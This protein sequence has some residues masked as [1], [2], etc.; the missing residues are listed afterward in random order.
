MRKILFIFLLSTITCVKL[1]AQCNAPVINSFSPNTGFIGSTVTITG[2]NFDPIPAN[3]QVFFGATQAT[4]Q[5]A[6]FGVLT[7]TVPVGATT[8]PVA[9]KNACNLIAYSNVSFNGIFCP[10]PINSTTYNNVAF[11]LGGVYGAYNMLA[12]DMDNDGKPD[13]VSAY[14]GL[15]VA[16]NNSTPGN[17]NFT[18]YNFGTA[19]NYNSSVSTA[20]FD[21]DGRRDIFTT[22]NIYRN[23]STGPGNINFQIYGAPAN[24]Y[25]GYQ[26]N[27]GDFNNDGKI[28]IVWENASGTMYF[29]MNTSTGP[30][31]I[32]FTYST[33]LYVQYRCTGIQCVDVDGDGKTDVL[34]T[35]GDGNRMIALRNTTTTGSG[36]FTFAG[37]QAFN[38]GGAYPYRCQIADFDKD[39]RIDLATVN[40]NSGANTVNTAVFRNTS[41][42][43]N[44]SFATPNTYAG[45]QNNYRIG[46]G[47]V[48]GDGYPDIVTKSLA[49]QAFAVYPNTSTGSG[50]ISFAN[51]FDYS[52]AATAEVSGIVIGDLDGD[53]VPDIAT[54]GVNS[55][56]IR[57]HRNT[58]SQ[59]DNT[60][61][62]AACKNIIAAL[63][64]TGSVTVTAAMI[65]NGSSDACGIGSLQ[66]N[67][68]ASVT[69]TCANIGANTVTL[70]VTDRAGNVSTCTS[71]VTVAPAAIIVAGQTTVCQGQTVTLTANQGDSYQWLKDGVIIPG[72]NSQSYVATVTGNYSV[73]VTNAGGCSGTSAETPVTVNLNPTVNVTPSGNAS[74]CPPSGKVVLSASTSSIYQWK[75]NGSN[76]S[77]ATQ[78]SY[79]ATA[80]G[81]YSVQVI[82]LFGCSATSS[83][84]SVSA[85]D[86]IAPTAR[87]KNVTVALNAAKTASVTVS[88]INNGSSDNCGIASVTISGQTTYGCTDVGNSIPVT[89]TVTDNSG[90]ISTCTA[91]VTVTDPNSYCNKIPVAVCK[92]LTLSANANCNADATAADFDGGSTDGD[93]DP[94]T[95]SVA[96]AGP[97][98]KGVTNVVLT[99]DDGRG[100]VSS[101][102][103]TVT[104]VDDQKPVITTDGNK[105]VNAIPGQCSADVTVSARA[106]DNCTVGAPSGTRSDNLPLNA[107][108]PV[109]TT[110]ITWTVV[111]A[112][113]NAAD[114]V[115]QTVTV[116]DIQAPTFL[117]NGSSNVNFPAG[118]GTPVSS[119]S[120]MVKTFSDPL[121]SGAVIT[122]ASLTYTAV[123]QGWGNTGGSA[124]IDI[125][126]TRIGSNVL[127]HYSTTQT[128]SYT[129]PLPNYVYGGTNTLKMYFLG[130][131]GWQSYW[132]GG[133]LTLYY[134]YQGCTASI[135]V[136]NDANK[137]GATVNIRIPAAVD[138]CGTATV[139]GTRS[140]GFPVTADYPVGVTTITWQAVDASGNT[141][142]CLQTVTVN[143]T[144]NPRLAGVPA[145]ATVECTSVPAAAVVTATD[146]CPGV[147]AVTYSEVKTDGSCAGNY[148]LTRSWSV[149]DAHGNSSTATQVITVV[150]TQA[151]SLTVPGDIVVNND[152]GQCGATVSFAASASDN[153]SG[154]TITYSQ[155]PGSFFGKGT[156]TVTVTATDAC[157]NAASQTFNV[158]VNDNEAP[159]LVGVP[160]NTTVEC[161]AVPAPAAVTATDNCPALN[162][163]QYSEVKANGSCPGNYT[164]TRTWTVTD[165]SGNG[166]TS[167]QVI[168]VVD[169][170][171][172]VL[173][174]PS[175]ISVSNDAGKCGAVVNFAAAAS[176][177]CSG[178]VITY[179]QQPGS[180]FGKGTTTVVVTATD[181]CGNASTG[182]FTVTVNDTE[183]PTIT[184]VGNQ[185]KAVDNA[186]CTYL[187]KGGEFNPAFADNCPGATIRN[188]YNNSN[189]LAGVTFAK[190][191]TTV[192]W[193]VTDAS[194]NTASCSFNV[195][196][197]SSL[198]ASISSSNVL[199]QGTQPNT[200]YVGYTP[201][202]TI[203]LK[204][205]PSGGGGT[206]FYNWSVSSNLQITGSS[207]SST[208]QVTTST[209]GSSTPYTV[210]LVVTDQYGCTVAATTWRIN[211]IDVR[212]GN[213]NDKVLVCQKTG[214]A[215]NPWVQ[216]CVAPAAVPAH[217][218]NGSTLGTCPVGF[219][220]GGNETAPAVA[221]ATIKAYPNPNTGVFELQ[222]QHYQAGKVQ[223]HVTDNYGKLVSQKSVAV[224]VVT[225]NYT[226][227]LSS[228]ASGVYHVTVIS[229][230]GVKSLKVAVVR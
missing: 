85:T 147:G 212:C 218:A 107:S 116:S 178:A 38:S 226:I 62:T 189:T 196:V 31:N 101:C 68:A 94:L 199:P 164:L 22:Y 24:N 86:D 184:C 146:N 37:I 175:N 72:A 181:A 219:A 186:G 142:T 217:L 73:T 83:T 158:T 150:D 179:S 152:P 43:G 44:I 204:A 63:S 89:L 192:T 120:P 173:T 56:T 193:T 59:T 131:P 4:V 144:E 154:A 48:N 209:P 103:T 203:T 200:I 10:T 1:I 176:D 129:G 114:P 169:T 108:Y 21:G 205:N 40:Y 201:A 222:L 45:P 227:D 53:F 64:P 27:V 58:S 118:G 139:S 98:A 136:N 125:A 6:S 77:G 210:S 41:S 78:Q 49:V 47:D 17:L 23:I 84:I 127:W 134:T 132:Q 228:H 11:E 54:S 105:S 14:S 71:T 230:E 171:A 55:N 166:A 167:S 51:R 141:A 174:V 93:G 223:I 26:G 81:T 9:V 66:I 67:N 82:D 102:A 87:C 183:K 74:L 187:V 151:P 185:S 112:D 42:V 13:V 197:T 148:T 202:Q 99:V 153:C 149:T 79:T 29:F 96:P 32:S 110:T 80:A 159:V 39:G 19:G 123:D 117:V 211:V 190:G 119:W 113:G 92:A 35:Q 33:S 229:S 28:D 130:Y 128:L 157:G 25:G 121:P 161:T 15:T 215:S 16:R 70:K 182:S 97:Y 220:R 109:G 138:N 213:K 162:D 198:A 36:T 188:S 57:F 206:Y 61:P 208:V 177:D 214:S 172:P 143:D 225:E 30:G 124:G 191:T 133:V 90:N 115:T 135:T 8:A 18:A 3:N 165:A 34:A 156:T 221:A 91:Q 52:S 50:T 122:G 163:V 195:T 194:G 168:T 155:Q 7:V 88:D 2:A 20:D 145:N 111:D 126:D 140:D 46:V 160:S 76:I 180:F 5:T 60:P 106:T 12:Q 216:I 69:F 224:G 170:K 207:S 65:D 137:C 104:V 100:G 95:F 75:L